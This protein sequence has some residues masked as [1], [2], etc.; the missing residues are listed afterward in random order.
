MNWSFAGALADRVAVVTGGAGGIGAG[1]CEVLAR[2]GARLA[3]GYR[4]SDEKAEAL[5]RRLPGG[6]HCAVLAPVTDSAALEACAREVDARWQRCDL[7]VN[8]AG[9]TRFVPHA[10]L[11][12]LPDELFDTIFATNV[13]GPFATVR[14][15]KPLLERSPGSLI[16]NISSVAARIAMGSNVAYC[17]SKAAVDNM[18][19]SLARALAPAIRVVSVAPGLVETGFISDLDPAWLKQQREKTVLGRLATPEQIGLA[20]LAAAVALPCSTGVIV[21]VDGGRALA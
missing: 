2:A 9:T 15:F 11:D 3:I 1:V 18:T 6:P 14:A 10:D 8:C 12:G 13:R 7:L 19:Q 17:A 21:P 4:D 16:V 20:V 5:A